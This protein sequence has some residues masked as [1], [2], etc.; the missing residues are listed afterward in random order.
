MQRRAIEKHS[1]NVTEQPMQKNLIDLG[2]KPMRPF[3]DERDAKVGAA[4]LE[5]F[6]EGLAVEA[7]WDELLKHRVCLLVGPAHCGKTSELKLLRLRLREKDRAC[8][9][10]D[11]GTLARS[12]VE[13]AMGADRSAFGEWCRGDTEGIFLLDALDEAELCDDKALLVC[14]SKV[15]SCL[16]RPALQRSR[17]VVSSRP[18]SWSSA[19]VLD[20]IHDGL[21]EQVA[22]LSDS[23]EAESAAASLF[24][25]SNDAKPNS[26][27]TFASLPPL[28][29]GQANRLLK[30][31]HGVEHPTA[32]QDKAWN[33]GLAFALRNPGS[34]GWLARVVPKLQLGDGRHRAYEY[35]VREL[36]HMGFERR[37]QATQFSEEDVSDEIERL[38]AASFFCQKYL[39]SLRASPNDDGAVSLREALA[40]RPANFETL[41]QTFPFFMD[42]G[43]QR[44]KLLPSELQPF[45]VAKWLFRRIES[46]AMTV[47]DVLDLFVLKSFAGELIPSQFELVAGWLSSMDSEFARRILDVAPHAVLLYGDL[48]CLPHDLADK[49]LR[50]TISA[51]VI[52]RV[53]LYRTVRLTSDDYWQA[54]RPDLLPTVVSSLDKFAHNDECWDLLT[55]LVASRGCAEAVPALK[56][57]LTNPRASEAARVLAVDAISECGRAADVEWAIDG[58]FDR[59]LFNARTATISLQSLLQRNCSV[60]HLR[61]VLSSGQFESIAASVY[62]HDIIEHNPSK[63]GA[64]TLVTTLQGAAADVSEPMADATMKLLVSSVEALLCRDDLTV[65]DYVDLLDILEVVRLKAEGR[66]FDRFDNIP[67]LVRVR[68]ELQRL[69]VQRLVRGLGKDQLWKLR[70]HTEELYAHI[71]EDDIETLEQLKTELADAEMMTQLQHLIKGVTLRKT[72]SDEQHQPDRSANIEATVAA[73]KVQIEAKAEEISSCSNPAILTHLVHAATNGQLR[74]SLGVEQWR[75]L[76]AKYG[77]VVSSA[78]EAG[79]RR[80]WRDHAPLEDDDKPQLVYP[81]TIAGLSGVVAEVVDAHAAK[82]LSVAEADQAMRYSLYELNHFPPYVEFLVDTRFDEC[83]VF[84]ASV[85]EKWKTSLKAAEHA[86]HVV[87]WLPDKLVAG[88]TRCRT[89]IWSYI[90]AGA[91]GSYY[92]VQKALSTLC[93]WPNDPELMDFLDKK[94]RHCWRERLDDFAAYFTAWM[95]VQPGPALA[96]LADSAEEPTRQVEIVGLASCWSRKRDNPLSGIEANSEELA[97]HLEKL[98]EVIALAAPP[99]TDPYRTGV[100]TPEARDNAGQFRRS[101]LQMIESLGSHA[102]YVAAKRLAL[103][104]KDDAPTAHMLDAVAIRIAER[105]ALPPPWTTTQF[106]DFSRDAMAVPVDDEQSLWRRVRRDTRTA[107]ENVLSGRFHIG[108]L[109]KKGK[110]RDMQLWLARELEL[111]SKQAYSVQ[112]ESELADRT[113]PDI[114]AE[115]PRHMTTLELKVVEDR[116]VESLLYDLE[117]QLKGDYLRDK[118]SN[119]GIFVVMHQGSRTNFPFQKRALSFEELRQ[120]LIRRADELS[121]ASLGKKHLEVIAFECP[122]GHSP[123]N[124]KR[125]TKKARNA[126]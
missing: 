63:A 47:D 48:S 126:E 17:F 16:G 33:L 42:S 9:M 123:R 8:F 2:R 93:K 27:L 51:M 101:I 45:L 41:L 62:V 77:M 85:V 86:K 125:S 5:A 4:L 6:A 114:R 38:C 60:A 13:D 119:H 74:T 40:H 99:A 55:R 110:E 43:I 64:L 124:A 73:D 121:A 11:L 15:A 92:E 53:L 68:P 20:T 46:R 59:G 102:A 32:L 66:D 90:N 112:R 116:T 115:T 12:T 3:E 29:K 111:L 57:Q 88:D 65:S 95:Q 30:S 31:I 117:W 103:K 84:Y 81:Q 1:R 96:F 89:A 120:V 19:D 106:V 109:L 18:G 94:S 71:S 35:A 72:P 37:R 100:F 79:L 39:F 104:F 82:A 50:K 76:K 87:A 105:V 7:T 91:C 80:L 113:M 56:R 70:S 22:L 83:D 107:V 44:L 21:C 98:Y 78:L 67:P 52:G 28:T 108:S 58:L 14:I 36:V 118:R 34:L 61:R 25:V 69:A 26:A 97:M 23:S 54:M 24:E 75:L 49:A 10:L 122:S